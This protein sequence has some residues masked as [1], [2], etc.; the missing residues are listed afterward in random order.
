MCYFETWLKQ[1]LES[2]SIKCLLLRYCNE[3]NAIGKEAIVIIIDLNANLKYPKSLK[4]LVQS[5]N[6]P[7]CQ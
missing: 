3:S 2:K 1:C 7:W 6:K 4:V 5:H